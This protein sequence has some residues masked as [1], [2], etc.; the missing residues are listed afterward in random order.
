MAIAFIDHET[1]HHGDLVVWKM[2]SLELADQ[3]ATKWLLADSAGDWWLACKFYAV[4]YRAGFH[5]PVA[6]V[7]RILAGERGSMDLELSMRMSEEI[8]ALR[9][10]PA[11]RS[12]LVV[13]DT[14]I[15]DRDLIVQAIEEHRRL[16]SS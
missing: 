4:R 5:V 1:V 10:S 14:D 15:L 2:P 9:A 16:W 11:V 6:R 12:D 7:V 13:F 8:R 3:F